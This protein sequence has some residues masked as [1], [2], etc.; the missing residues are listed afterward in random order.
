[1]TQHRGRDAA[2][3]E[4]L[5]AG[6]TVRADHDQLGTA[7]LRDL[8]DD[9]ARRAGAVDQLDQDPA[10]GQLLDLL[11]EAL[12]FFDAHRGRDFAE[13]LEHRVVDVLDRRVVG[14]RV[15]HEKRRVIE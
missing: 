2:E 4:P 12:R 11:G 5:Q 14:L 1:V 3:Q 8:R 13:L 10:R 15:D 9:L 6:V 7:F